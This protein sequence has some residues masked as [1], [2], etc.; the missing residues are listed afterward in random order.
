MTVSAAPIKGASTP[1]ASAPQSA[2]AVRRGAEF[3]VAGLT[4]RYRHAKDNALQDINLAISPGEAVAIIGRSGCGKS[5][6]LH[7]IAGLVKPSEG[8][9]LIDGATVRHP[10]PRWVMAVCFHGCPILEPTTTS[11]ASSN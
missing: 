11:A 10:S 4:H 2:V 9:V 3:R 5:T 1:L 7:I 6:L 8:R